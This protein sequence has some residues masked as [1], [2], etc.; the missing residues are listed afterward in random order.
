MVQLMYGSLPFCRYILSPIEVSFLSFIMFQTTDINRHVPTGP[1]AHKSIQEEPA[2]SSATQHP[3]CVIPRKIPEVIATLRSH[4]T[5][6][7]FNL[8]I[9]FS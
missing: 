8:L 1:D 7:C 6:T 3:P 5:N 2:V 9:P 4:P